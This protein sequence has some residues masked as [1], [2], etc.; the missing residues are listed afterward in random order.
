MRCA[1]ES[2]PISRWND[3]LSAAYIPEKW[4][5]AHFGERFVNENSAVVNTTIEKAF[6]PIRGI[7]KKRL[8]WLSL[9]VAVKR[10]FRSVYGW[11]RHAQRPARS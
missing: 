6:A 11:R 2:T 3:S 10:T 5:K 7:G 9:D 4:D 8:L 1:L